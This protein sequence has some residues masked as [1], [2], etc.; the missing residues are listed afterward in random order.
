[1]NR[2]F[3]LSVST[4]LPMKASRRKLATN[5][6]APAL[7]LVIASTLVT[8]Q[9]SAKPPMSRSSGGQAS[10]PPLSLSLPLPLAL[11]RIFE[12]EAEAEEERR[13]LSHGL[14]S[15]TTPPP[16]AAPGSPVPNQ[17]SNPQTGIL[18]SRS[19]VAPAVQIGRAVSGPLRR[20]GSRLSFLPEPSAFPSPPLFLP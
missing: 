13:I 7:R 16:I 9:A 10:H 15:P 5:K 3:G 11:A 6:I 12:E 14:N 1:M 8:N 17:C 18:A 20:C 2:M 19:A 4:A